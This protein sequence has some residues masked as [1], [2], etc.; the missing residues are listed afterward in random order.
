MGVGRVIG[1]VLLALVA[2][3]AAYWLG[4][5][6]IP[7]MDRGG[8][9]GGLAREPPLTP[10]ELAEAER[11]LPRG[12]ITRYT[13]PEIARIMLRDPNPLFV[14]A[15][16]LWPDDLNG[17]L[18]D[19]KYQRVI[20]EWVMNEI[21]ASGRLW[22]LN[23]SG[24]EVLVF[25]LGRGYTIP[26]PGISLFQYREAF[27][28]ILKDVGRIR[29]TA[30]LYSVEAIALAKSWEDAV[31]LAEEKLEEW[32]ERG[33]G[34]KT[35]EDLL[36]PYARGIAARGGGAVDPAALRDYMC[37]SQL[38]AALG[39][40][41]ALTPEECGAVAELMRHERRSLVLALELFA[42]AVAPQMGYSSATMI[43][44]VSCD[45]DSGKPVIR[46][47]FFPKGMKLPPEKKFEMARTYILFR[48]LEIPVSYSVSNFPAYYDG[49]FGW[50]VKAMA[51]GCRSHLAK[52]SILPAEDKIL[53]ADQPEKFDQLEIWLIRSFEKGT[54]LEDIERGGGPYLIYRGMPI[55]A[56]AGWLEDEAKEANMTLEEY[57]EEVYLP[58]YRYIADKYV[59][60]YET[61][62]AWSTQVYA[63][64]EE[65]A[66]N[67]T[68]L[69]YITPGLVVVDKGTGGKPYTATWLYVAEWRKVR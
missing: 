44:D 69:G 18:I 9:E 11:R 64:L 43:I 26:E 60:I 1:A 58:K 65:V 38:P 61:L 45:L 62:R 28:G 54:E 53:Y 16:M 48:S 50:E 42:K 36:N 35:L 17:L 52:V 46:G 57:V 32:R 22:R 66:R 4:L 31:K 41:R 20:D 67:I 40:R 29:S 27:T 8:G 24:V 37:S 10:E 59:L 25:E 30:P 19:P 13:P 51:Y 7:L 3:A 12:Y 23:L 63:F 15:P 39:Y 2:L 56:Y 14:P 55:A 33:Y 6:D 49:L 34:E 21:L 47:V 68:T 5:I